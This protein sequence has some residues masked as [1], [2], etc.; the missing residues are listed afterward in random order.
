MIY[1]NVFP[2][3]WST[4]HPQVY[5]WPLKVFFVVFSKL[6]LNQIAKNKYFMETLLLLMLK[7]LSFAASYLSVE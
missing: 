7:L 4:I 6:I 3:R 2:P 1:L 5:N